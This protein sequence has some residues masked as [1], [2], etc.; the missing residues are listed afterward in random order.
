MPATPIDPKRFA[1]ERVIVT[2]LP[3][4]QTIIEW[5]LHPKF[6]FGTSLPMFY[7]EYARAGGEW[8]RLNPDD[9]VVNL[10]VYIDSNE[11]RC[12]LSN[13]VYYRVVATDGVTEYNSKPQA[14]LG[15][16]NSRDYRIAREVIR[17]EYLRLK[18][19]VGAK[20]YLLKRRNHGVPCQAPGCLDHDLEVPVT[21][22]CPNCFGT[23]FENGYY[24][25]LVFW[26]DLSGT[27]SVKD[28]QL[29]LGTIDDKQ[30]TGRCVAY[31]R[32]DTYD[33]WVEGDTNKRFNIRQVQTAVEMRGKPLVYMLELREI[34][35]GSVEY[36]I[37]LEQD[38]PPLP[39]GESSVPDKISTEGWRKGITF[40]IPL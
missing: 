16:L 23:G 27:N 13:D 40:E 1:F 4:N 36:T 7:V 12:N 31:P 15:S 6:T 5:M 2:V 24:N 22:N 21:S 10:C 11:Y 3:N 30:R 18:K 20:G 14:T 34:P 17:K 9:P 32:V 26:I 29:P 39:E 35:A 25:A 8:C 19:Y 33:V 37:P 38:V 28:V